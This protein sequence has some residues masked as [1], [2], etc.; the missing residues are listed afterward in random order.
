MAYLRRVF[1]RALFMKFLLVFLFCVAS[2]GYDLTGQVLPNR[3]LEK[4]ISYLNP[5][6]LNGKI[7]SIA[8]K[9][10]H[11][12]DRSDPNL[13]F[14]VSLVNYPKEPFWLVNYLFN[15]KGQLTKIE[16]ENFDSPYSIKDF[17]DYSYIYEFEYKDSLLVRS[18]CSNK[19]SFLSITEF[20]YKFDIHNRVTE[21]RQIGTLDSRILF[22]EIEYLEGGKK[23]TL[24]FYE[25]NNKKKLE[26]FL[27]DL[28]GHIIT[29][30]Y[31]AYKQDNIYTSFIYE[32]YYNKEGLQNCRIYNPILSNFSLG[33]YS[34]YKYNKDSLLKKTKN[35]KLEGETIDEETTYWK[36]KLK[37]TTKFSIRN[38]GIYTIQ[39]SKGKR[40]GKKLH[41]STYYI[42]DHMNNKLVSFVP[43]PYAGG[44][45]I[46]DITY[47]E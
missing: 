2:F 41:S 27:Y 45:Q 12:L 17:V 46:Y 39:K 8:Q 13:K 3:H 37:S 47:Y 15:D 9:S 38:K 30:K 4:N 14:S 1:T 10:Y 19:D 11:R 42:L 25:E 26:E 32:Y 20:D 28:N 23:S 36:G 24:Y 16:C 31:F 29:H 44:L 35:Y 40:N 21:I 34:I 6:S 22:E 5:F 33:Q 7:K 43:S 18:V